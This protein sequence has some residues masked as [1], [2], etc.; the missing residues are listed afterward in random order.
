MFKSADVKAGIYNNL[1]GDSYSSSN[2][3][4]SLWTTTEKE[5]IS[6]FKNLE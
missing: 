1:P 5:R 3:S 2:K 4:G 6:L